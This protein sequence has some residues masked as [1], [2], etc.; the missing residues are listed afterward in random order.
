MNPD[1]K[2]QLLKNCEIISIIWASLMAQMVNNLTAI[3]ETWVWSLGWEDPLEEQSTPVFLPGESHGQKSLVGYSPW[4][5][6]QSD[7]IERLS[8]A[9]GWFEHLF[10]NTEEVICLHILRESLLYRD[11]YGNIYGWNYG[12]WHLL[13]CN[14]AGYAVINETRL[15]LLISFA[16]GWWV[17]GV[18]Y[19]ST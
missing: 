3:Q 2:S 6:K 4:G 13:Q 12:V 16:A 10:E 1:L 18:P 19:M 8:T 9:Q 17:Y 7:T 5:C 15:V 14:P 11:I